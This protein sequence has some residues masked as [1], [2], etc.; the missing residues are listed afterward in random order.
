MIYIRE[1]IDD[2]LKAEIDPSIMYVL[3]GV[4]RLIQYELMQLL[5]VYK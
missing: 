4:S 3:L 2:I 1:Y 5:E